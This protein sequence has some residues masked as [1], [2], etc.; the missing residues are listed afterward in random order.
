MVA[1]RAVRDP[2]AWRPTAA[3][4]SALRSSAYEL[5]YGG[6]AGGG[7]TA[8]LTV[9]PIRWCHLASFRGLIL[10]RSFPELERTLI[11]ASREMYPRLG[12]R[13]HEQRHE[14]T[15]PSGARV[16]FGYCERD[17]DVLR[18]QGA[19][20]SFLGF[21]ELTHFS[22]TAYRYLTSR[23]RSA[24]ALPIRI[25][26][27]TNP[28]GPGHEWVRRRWGAWIGRGADALPGDV[29]W[30]DPEGREAAEGAPDALSRTFVPARLEDNPY[31]GAEYRAQLLALDPVTRAQLLDGDWDATIGEGKL[32][33]RDWWHY[34]D[35]VP[36]DC[37]ASVRAWDLGATADGDPTRGVLMHRRP[38]GAVPRWIVSDVVSVR[39]APHEVDA[40]VKRTAAMDGQRVTIVLP[41]DP[42]QAGVEQILRYQRDLAGWHVLGRRPVGDKVD[43]AK[44]L[45]SQVGARNVGLVRG[46]WVAA[47]VAELHAFPDGVH[48]D[49]VDAA[50]DAFA[51][52]L[53]APQA[54]SRPLIVRT[55]SD[56]S[57]AW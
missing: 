33:H 36:S 1:P 54:T 28:G 42:G 52:L 55:P 22:E 27:T 9:A 57:R 11:A 12:A 38:A 46:P 10:R 45:S 31:L 3:Q 49:Q 15:F 48:D 34:L 6:A 56:L 50:A 20:Y 39:G 29:R 40:A 14:W 51:T 43:R 5:L 35:A 19:E 8:Y 2:N 4:R 47:F 16:A 18:Y 24:D 44:P 41:Q 25:R 13:Y 7:K 21:D 17:A 53:N 37:D 30:F 26:A 23:A 32:F